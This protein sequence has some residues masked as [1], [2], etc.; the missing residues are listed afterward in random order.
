MYQLFFFFCYSLI[1]KFLLMFTLEDLS[2]KSFE[3]LNDIVSSNLKVLYNTR[4]INNKKISDLISEITDTEKSLEEQ[5]DKINKSLTN[6]LNDINMN[7]NKLNKIN[8]EIEQ[9]LP[10]IKRNKS[11]YDDKLKGLVDFSKELINT[12]TDNIEQLEKLNQEISNNMEIFEKG[13]YERLGEVLENISLTSKETLNKIFFG[14]TD[15]SLSQKLVDLIELISFDYGWKEKFLKLFTDIYASRILHYVKNEKDYNPHLLYFRLLGNSIQCALIP[16]FFIQRIYKIPDLTTEFVDKLENETVTVIIDS[17]YQAAENYRTMMQNAIEFDD[18]LSN[19][20]VK[21]SK[22]LSSI[23]FD[24]IKQ[25]WTLEELE[26]NKNVITQLFSDRNNEIYDEIALFLS[27]LESNASIYFTDNQLKQYYKDIIVPAVVLIQSSYQDWYEKS[28]GTHDL[29][30]IINSF[31]IFCIKIWELYQ[32]SD[33]SSSSLNNIYIKSREILEGWISS[34]VLMVFTPFKDS[35]TSYFKSIISNGKIAMS[36]ELF[37]S[38]T[39]KLFSSIKERMNENI[40]ECYF[41]PQFQSSIDQYFYA[42]LIRKFDFKDKNEIKNLFRDT[43]V[44]FEYFGTADFRRLRSIRTIV[45]D[46]KDKSFV[47]EIPDE[48]VKKIMIY[49]RS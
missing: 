12:P 1:L 38:D 21:T 33:M 24:K 47:I 46:K 34:I 28:E 29:V 41:L 42:E 25:Q 5:N 49:T 3:E 23:I 6:V 13:V 30:T 37:L 32:T 35:T 44:L 15:R 7:K 31:N 10:N 8:N 18:M 17:T 48:D 22:T 16:L 19:M 11:L 26:K 14:N 43:D 36:L 4:E 45:S 9:I 39:T 40:F 27:Y 2:K 20:N